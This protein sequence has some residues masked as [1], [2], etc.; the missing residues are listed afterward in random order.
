MNTP[1]YFLPLVLSA[2]SVTALSAAP[3]PTPSLGKVIYVGD[4]LT[5]GVKTP[6]YR[7]ELFKIYVDNNVKAEPV[8]VW[9]GSFNYNNNNALVY[10]GKTFENVH[11]AFCSRRAYQ[12]SGRKNSGAGAGS[13]NA[14]FSSIQNWLDV[15]P[16]KDELTKGGAYPGPRLTEGGAP[17]TMTILLGTNDILSDRN[18]SEYV[19]QLVED[20]QSIVSY[21]QKANPNLQTYI[22]TV[23]VWEKDASSGGVSNEQMIDAVNVYNEKISQWANSQKNVTVIDINKGI[24][25]VTKSAKNKGQGVDGFFIEDGLHF[26]NQ[27]NL[28]LGGNIAKGMGL[29]GRT[30]GLPRKVANQFSQSVGADGKAW[31]GP[32]AHGK[33]PVAKGA[34]I[35]D[36][37]AT[38]TSGNQ[39]LV[40]KWLAPVDDDFTTEITYR[41]ARTNKTDWTDTNSFSIEVGNGTE[42][43]TLN[44]SESMV[45]WGDTPIYSNDLTGHPLSVRIAHIGKDAE[46]GEPK[47]GFYV[48]L[49]GQLI[50]EALSSNSSDQKNGVV[51]SASSDQKPRVEISAV[52]A[53]GKALAP[54]LSSPNKKKK[55]K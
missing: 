54:S 7:Y 4:S 16:K 45:K 31:G 3:A 35:Q 19:P 49:D 27:G 48:W 42:T 33:A 12:T 25:D 23:P 40:Q 1:R 36:N 15:G 32:T 52:S 8:G 28:I 55:A 22:M 9:E 11:N 17:Q 13:G 24:Q 53:E 21:G 50:G 20:I 43:G 6:S 18:K 30:A 44:L 39:S 14:A 41:M 26:S 34:K 46:G 10:G 37:R 29:P 51:I 38:L 5:H 2:C 47:A